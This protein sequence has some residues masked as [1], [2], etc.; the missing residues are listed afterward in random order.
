[1]TTL[2]D[3]YD[4]RPPGRHKEITVMGDR[5]I[6][7]EADGVDEYA[8]GPDAQLQL[9]RSDRWLRQAMAAIRGKLGA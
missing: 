5:V 7:A 1:M 9:L 4:Q 2:K 3:L 8:L 6:V